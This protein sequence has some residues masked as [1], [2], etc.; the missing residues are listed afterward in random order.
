MAPAF[1]N[2][3]GVD[4]VRV[5]YASSTNA[6]HDLRENVNR[7]FAPREI[8]E[9]CERDRDCRIDVSTRDASRNPNSEC[10]TWERRRVFTALDMAENEDKLTDGPGNID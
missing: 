10:S 9:S 7:D 5:D 3:D 1:N 6:A 8:S 2:V 4:V